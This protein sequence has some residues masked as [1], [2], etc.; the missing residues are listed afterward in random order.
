[1]KISGVVASNCCMGEMSTGK[2]PVT[3]VLDHVQDSHRLLI[4]GHED[5]MINF[6]NEEEKQQVTCVVG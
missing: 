1:V 5:H 2:E 4:V 6:V 3:P